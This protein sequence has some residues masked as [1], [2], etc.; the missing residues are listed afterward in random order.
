MHLELIS[1]KHITEL[2]HLA[3]KNREHLK[4]WFPWVSMIQIV[5]FFVRFVEMTKRK[6]DEGIEKSYVIYKDDKLVG[7]IGIYKIDQFNSNTEIGYWID[8]EHEGLG[9]TSTTCREVIMREY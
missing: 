3:D 4:P 9:I 1:K 8:K 7:R 5:D 6:I 2:Y